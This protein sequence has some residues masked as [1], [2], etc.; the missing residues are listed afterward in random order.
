[1]PAMQSSFLCFLALSTL[2]SSQALAVTA[3][4]P[5]S[6]AAVPT[7]GFP[8]PPGT[9]D[10]HYKIE[11]PKLSVTSCLMNA[12]AALKESALED[13]DG[14]I[15]DGTE[16]R[17]DGFPEV[18]IVITT[19]RRKRNVRTRFVIWAIFFGVVKMILKKKFEFAQFEMESL[20]AVVGWVHVTNN[21]IGA[22]LLIEDRHFN[23]TPMSNNAASFPSMNRTAGLKSINITN[24]I[25]TDNANDPA[26]ERLNVTFIPQSDTLG[27]N[28]VFVPVM[29]G[30]ADM[31]QYP[32]TH[33]S[34]VF[35][36]GLLKDFKGTICIFPWVPM[37]T[38]PPFLEYGWLIRAIARIPTYMLEKRRFGALKFEI[39]VDKVPVGFGVLGLGPRCDPE[40]SLAA[41][42]GVT[43]S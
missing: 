10:L 29:S 37:R 20:G 5:G 6:V 21:P 8:D 31:A 26:E 25:T 35:I 7:L 14:R 42:L 38:A 11:G 17:L 24:L 22:V 3:L 34:S 18:S 36:I 9:F 23:G 16:Y 28:D 4:T 27:I 19:P 30:L 32:S 2:L 1:M 13:W 39:E 43:E 40:A 41:S 15:V 12:V 33:Q